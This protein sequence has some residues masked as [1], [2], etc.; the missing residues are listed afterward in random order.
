[1]N[2]RVISEISRVKELMGVINENIESVLTGGKVLRKGSKGPDVEK[3]QKLLI[4]MGYD[5]GDFGPNKD[6]VDGSFGPTVDK[7]IR[8]FQDKNGLKVDGKVGKNTLSSMISFGIQK[9]PDFLKISLIKL[10]LERQLWY[11]I[12]NLFGGEKDKSPKDHF[13]F[14]FAFPGYQPKFDK[15][16]RG[17]L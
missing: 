17:W 5:L 15:T 4:K 12:E 11:A 9:I 3:L 1:M 13:V 16:N 6:G 10:V 8:E 14:Y 7:I 2:R